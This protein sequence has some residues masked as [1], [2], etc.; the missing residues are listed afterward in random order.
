MCCFKII[1]ALRVAKIVEVFKMFPYELNEGEIVK[2]HL[3]HT[4]KLEFIVLFQF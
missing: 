1:C 4:Q 3:K 2:I